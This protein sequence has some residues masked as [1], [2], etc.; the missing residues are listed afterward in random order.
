M[1]AVSKRKKVSIQ[2]KPPEIPPE[3][4]D[5]LEIWESKSVGSE[6]VHEPLQELIPDKV[7]KPKLPLEPEPV[8]VPEW[9]PDWAPVTVT[10]RPGEST[11]TFLKREGREVQVPLPQ[12]KEKINVSKN[13]GRTVHM[14]SPEELSC[15]E[16]DGYKQI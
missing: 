2:P 4:K 10:P 14:I 3:I 12:V 1:A 9:V 6:G 11:E 7:A 8:P 13:G 5:E 16:C 15:W